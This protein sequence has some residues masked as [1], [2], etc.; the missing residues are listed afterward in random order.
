VLAGSPTARVTIVRHFLRLP[1]ISSAVGSGKDDILN[2]VTLRT[3]ANLRQTA[4][5]AVAKCRPPTKLAGVEYRLM[6]K[7]NFLLRLGQ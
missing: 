7:S 5:K 4:Q 6:F 3:L 2:S 1:H